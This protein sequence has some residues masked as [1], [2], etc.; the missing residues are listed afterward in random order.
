MSI[1]RF[2]P[3][4]WAA[5]LLSKLEKSLVY[6]QPNVVNRDYE[7]EITA[8]GDSVKI[9]SVSDPTIADYVPGSTVISPENLT[10]AQRTLVIDQSKYF[11]FQIDDVD[12]RQA[13][14]NIMTNVMERAAYKLK[15][16]ADQFIASLYTGVTSANNLG[17]ISVTTAAPTDAYSKILVPL[18]VALDDSDVPTDGRYVVIP[19]W[20]HGRLLLDDRF[21]KTNEAG[22]DTGLRNGM[23]GRAAGFDVLLSNNA[24]LV[25]GDDYAVL[26]G[27]PMAI[28]YAEQINST[29][30]YR[31]QSSFSDAV[32]GLHLYGAKVVYPDAL[33]VAIASQT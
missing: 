33:A 21:I 19:P 32:K 6:G 4:I 11:A 7:G 14:G 2:K 28:S 27:T 18:K 22:T 17:T 26:A 12:K 30:A 9:T 10:D 3:Q 20:L 15:D 25:T 13:A 5:V 8:G 24:P 23:V 16:A 1:I 29:E 31:P